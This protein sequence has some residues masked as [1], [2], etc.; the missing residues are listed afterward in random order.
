MDG[1]LLSKNHCGV[2]IGMCWG[3]VKQ[4]NLVIVEMYLH[5]I[6]IGKNW[7]SLFRIGLL[8]VFGDH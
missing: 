4:L 8:I 3:K 7:Q 2:A 1:V 5:A 6:V